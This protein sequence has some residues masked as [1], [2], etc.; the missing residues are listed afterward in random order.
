M[1]ICTEMTSR[2]Q[3]RVSELVHEEISLLLQRESRDPRFALVTVTDVEVSADLRSARVFITVLG[4]EPEQQDALQALAHAAGYLRRELSSRLR[5]RR[6]PEL[7]FEL[8]QAV[9][10]GSRILELLAS[11]DDASQASDQSP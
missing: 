7:T 1:T 11:L 10:R 3:E 4:E 6:I 2:R 8:D 9:A 5:L